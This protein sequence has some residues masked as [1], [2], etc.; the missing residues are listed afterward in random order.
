MHPRLVSSVTPVVFI[1]EGSVPR[2]DPVTP[3]TRVVESHSGWVGRKGGENL[4]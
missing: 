2:D 4:I 3:P 1:V